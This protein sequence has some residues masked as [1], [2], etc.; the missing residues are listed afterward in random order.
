MKNPVFYL[1][2]ALVAFVTMCNASNAVNERYDFYRSVI[3]MDSN[4]PNF[5]EIESVFLTK[6]EKTPEELIAVDNAI[7]ENNISNET[8]TLDF[9]FINANSIVDEVIESAKLCDI[10]KTPEELIAEDNAIT[11]NNISNETQTLDFD[12][13]NA[14]SIV[15][16]VIESAK[17]CDIEKTPEELIAEDNAI[18]ENN[19]SNEISAL[20]FKIINRHLNFGI[21]NNKF[22]LE[23]GLKS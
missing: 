15:D 10:E 13:I 8:Q 14:N 17:P 2:I 19:I 22:I 6:I 20:D 4:I 21:R 23:K 3:L 7:M 11:E 1:G 18:T 5:E 12:F 16:E 9:N